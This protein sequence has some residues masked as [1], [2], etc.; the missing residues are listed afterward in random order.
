MR[1]PSQAARQ[2]KCKLTASDTKAQI[3]RFVSKQQQTP[4]NGS[5]ALPRTQ[6]RNTSIALSAI[7]SE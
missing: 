2:K 4:E 7:G 1:S 3:R 6:H 5:S